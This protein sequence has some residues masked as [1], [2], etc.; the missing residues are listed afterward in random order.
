MIDV[1]MLAAGGPI[2]LGAALGLAA[3]RGIR[4]LDVKRSQRLAAQRRVTSPRP[5]P[6]RAHTA[7]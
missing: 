4:V 7:R 3:R 2:L 6:V 1:S 5:A